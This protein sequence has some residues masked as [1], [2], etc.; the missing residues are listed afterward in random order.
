[1]PAGKPPDVIDHVY[2]APPPLEASATL[3]ACPTTPFDTL[4]VAMLSVVALTLRVNALV[5]VTG[6]DAASVALTVNVALTGVAG[7]P[8]INPEVE[9]LKPAG[10]VP[11]VMVQTIGELPPVVVS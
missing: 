8:E 1:M 3:Y 9:R 5:T 4:V 11:E 7:V 2:G 6:V 10:S